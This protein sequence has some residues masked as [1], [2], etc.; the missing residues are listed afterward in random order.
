[1]RLNASPDLVN[2][3]ILRST[4]DAVDDFDDDDDDDDYT[5]TENCKAVKF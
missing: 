2:R 3:N 1:M 5:K 4:R